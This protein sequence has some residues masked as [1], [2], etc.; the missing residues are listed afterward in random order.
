M[1]NYSDFF[2]TL[3]D[4]TVPAG[5]LG[6]GAHYSI[7]R[8]TV[9]H[10]PLGRPLPEGRF[11]DF[12]VI[13]DED[14]DVRVIE[15]IEQIYRAGILSSFI[16]FGERDRLFTAILSSKVLAHAPG[17]PFD[18]AFLNTI[19]ELGLSPRSANCLKNDGIVYIGELI[20]RYEADLLRA[21]NF[22][23]RSLQ[24]IKQ[25]LARVGLQ[26]GMDVPGWEDDK[27]ENLTK[28]SGQIGVLKAKVQTICQSLN[29]P[30]TSSVVALR[31]FRNTIIDDRHEKVNL[32]LSN[33]EMLWH[34]GLAPGADPQSD[35]ER[36]GARGEPGADENDSATTRSVGD[37][38]SADDAAS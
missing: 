1:R 9:F 15:P 3:Y 10:D 37:P 7:L 30:L 28:D 16:M 20:Q 29:E 5:Y 33:V 14:H 2:K 6:R 31:D 8:A 19:D 11:T 36:R 27:I 22:G 17:V 34:L 25:A 23:R 13:W 4:E 26:L 32:Y 35:N 12:A 18:P 21:P 24:E 38:G